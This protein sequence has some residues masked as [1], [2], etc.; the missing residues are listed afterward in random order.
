MS[1]P[2]GYGDRIAVV[3]DATVYYNEDPGTDVVRYE[4]TVEIYNGWVHFDSLQGG[5]VPREKIEQIHEF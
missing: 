3:E 4:G 2:E 5:W 1:E